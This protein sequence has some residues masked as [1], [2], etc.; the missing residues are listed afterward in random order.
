VFTDSKGKLAEHLISKFVSP[1]QLNGFEEVAIK[2]KPKAFP[3]RFLFAGSHLLESKEGPKKYACDY[4]GNVISVS[5]FGDELLCLLGIYGHHDG[6][7][8]WQV[9]SEELPEIGTTVILR[10]RPLK[11]TKS[12]LKFYENQASA[13]YFPCTDRCAFKLVWEIVLQ[14]GFKIY[15]LYSVPRA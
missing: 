11:K 15:L 5:T 3:S 10:L 4:S 13:L 9:N 12:K 1:A 2:E 8:S 14:D 6:G 7:L